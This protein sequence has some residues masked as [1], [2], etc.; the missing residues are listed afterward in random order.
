MERINNELINLREKTDNEIFEVYKQVAD[1]TK[2]L[3]DIWKITNNL[4]D[5]FEIYEKIKKIQCL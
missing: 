4:D 5:A 1:E 3:E 2:F